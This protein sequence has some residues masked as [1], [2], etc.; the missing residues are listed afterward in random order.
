[1]TRRQARSPVLR[2]AG[3]PARPA[4]V[5]QFLVALT[6]TDPLVWRR[7]QVPD[8]YTFW[9]LHV[10]IQDA[11]GWHDSHLHE[12]VLHR[13][14]TGREELIGLPDP[15]FPNQ[16]PV[17]AGWKVRVAEYMSEEAPVALYLYD[18]GDDW[19]HTVTYE[20]SQ[21][22]ERGRKYP[23]CLAGAQA[24]PPEDVGGT[25]GFCAFLEAIGDANHP[26]H[27]EYLTWVGGRYDPEAFDP[28][29]VRFA[30]PRER[31]K[32]AFEE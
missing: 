1:M 32:R 18:F 15:D 4:H 17:R 20:G 22:A 23:V 3:K 7:I 9:D 13:S 25:P 12:F 30:D 8:H 10:A 16:R 5:L 27:A 6:E 29:A 24:C 28:S 26:E 2:L 14:R 19:R 21:P 11:M 31:L